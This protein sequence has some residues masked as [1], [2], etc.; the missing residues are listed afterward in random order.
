MQEVKKVSLKKIREIV[1]K[2]TDASYKLYAK[3]K[4]NYERV[5]KIIYDTD[6]AGLQIN[7]H[8]DIVL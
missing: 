7:L 6:G 1:D 2:F 3:G 5:M 8:S 4:I